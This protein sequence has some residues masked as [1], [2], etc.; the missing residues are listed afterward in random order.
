[1]S[2]LDKQVYINTVLGFKLLVSLER[3]PQYKQK[4]SISPELLFFISQN[5]K[6]TDTVLYAD[7]L[8]HDDLILLAAAKA[9]SKI[10]N[11]NIV[12]A[13]TAHPVLTENLR[14]NGAQ[15]LV[16]FAYIGMEEEGRIH[17]LYK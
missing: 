12:M 16:S 6:P 9:V 11:F 8:Y 1:M 10:E 14:M 13:D 3:A 2:F 17:K 15:Q 5:I 4:G 7:Q